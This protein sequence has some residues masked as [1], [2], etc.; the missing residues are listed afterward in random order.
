MQM[1]THTESD[2][3]SVTSTEGPQSAFKAL[4]RKLHDKF[5]S[6]PR[7]KTSLANAVEALKRSNDFEST[8][9]QQGE[10]E[11]AKDESPSAALSQYQSE[12]AGMLQAVAN[13]SLTEC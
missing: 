3:V 8:L 9:T 12:Y 4:R 7:R 2:A 5:R 11:A 1:P 6:P 13:Y 10:S